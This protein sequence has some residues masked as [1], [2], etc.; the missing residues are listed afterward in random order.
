[1]KC[2][3]CASEASEAM[4][5]CPVCHMTLRY[6]C[7]SCHHE[8]GHGG[9]CDQCGVDFLKYMSAVISA[10]KAA[11]NANHERNLRRSELLKDV[12]FAPFT[13]GLP[14]IRKLLIGGRNR[15]D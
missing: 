12:F 15:R 1:M 6:E 9:T 14:I 7:P 3:K 5:F 2:P 4:K 8:Q 13:A 11:A 10:Q